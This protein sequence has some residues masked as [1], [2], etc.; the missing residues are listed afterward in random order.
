MRDEKKMSRDRRNSGREEVC[1][2]VYVADNFQNRRS[3]SDT[4]LDCD[5]A[6]YLRRKRAT[7]TALHGT[8]TIYVLFLFLPECVSIVLPRI[9]TTGIMTLS[10]SHL[11]W[12]VLF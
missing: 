11:K 5:R 12:C 8:M 9:T 2:I 4:V 1:F 6:S 10:F 7:L 3:R